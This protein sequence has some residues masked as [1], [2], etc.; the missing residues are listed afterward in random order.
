MPNESEQIRYKIQEISHKRKV[1]GY[2]AFVYFVL[3]EIIG[4][5]EGP[6]EE[7]ITGGSSDCGIDAFWAEGDTV[8]IL[9]AKYYAELRP[10]GRQSS[11]R[12]TGHMEVRCSP[13]I[14]DII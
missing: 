9:Q 7:A 1:Q 12:H 4:L 10:S 3:R 8:N 14:S 5:E 13:K 2:E 11:A 6:C